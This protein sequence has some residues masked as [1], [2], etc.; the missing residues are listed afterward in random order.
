M[1]MKNVQV[2]TEIVTLANVVIGFMQHSCL[3]GTCLRL[4][5][6]STDSHTLISLMHGRGR[7][8]ILLSAIEL[9]E[10]RIC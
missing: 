6:K 4:P 8:L 3:L 1:S 9:A 10:H 7:A 2:I 5:P